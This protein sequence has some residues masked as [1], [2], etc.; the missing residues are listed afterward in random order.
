MPSPGLTR[1]VH[2][3]ASLAL[4]VLLC[5]GGCDVLRDS[6]EDRSGAAALD[7][8]RVINAWTDSVSV[9]RTEPRVAVFDVRVTLPDPCHD[10]AGVATE[11]VGRR[12][13]VQ[14]R[15]RAWPGGCITV[16]DPRRLPEL[17]VRVPAPGRYTVAFWRGDDRPPIERV[18]DVP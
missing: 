9:V 4:P 6:L 16:I 17:S 5:L 12:V 10:D 1:P 8:P 11:V 3:V 13:S 2:R 14:V 7:P 18:V 15:A